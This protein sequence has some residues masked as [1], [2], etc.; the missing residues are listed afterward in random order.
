M[1]SVAPDHRAANP[2]QANSHGWLAFEVLRRAAGQELEAAEY[3]RRLFDPSPDIL[4]LANE[5]PGQRNAYQNLKHIRCD[6]SRGTVVVFPP[7]PKSWYLLARCGAKKPR[8][9]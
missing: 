7:L 8:V 4:M 9:G 2:R 1:L 6:I 5:I 3:E